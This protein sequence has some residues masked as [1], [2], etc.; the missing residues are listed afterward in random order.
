MCIICKLL[1]L[2]GSGRN[3]DLWGCLWAVSIYGCEQKKLFRN[4][5]NVSYD[6]IRFWHCNQLQICDMWQGLGD[7]V[8]ARYE[9][10]QLPPTP[11]TS[12]YSNC[13]LLPNLLHVFLQ[14][15]AI[16]QTFQLHY[17]LCRPRGL[18][19]IC[20]YHNLRPRQKQ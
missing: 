6:Y 8:S 3:F 16:I 9:T 15:F 20:Q 13:Y 5:F 17:Y 10:T 4:A 19:Y 1:A 2:R 11:I 7:V 18:T 12:R 14:N